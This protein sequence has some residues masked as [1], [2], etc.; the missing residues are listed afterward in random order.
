M[1]SGNPWVP[2]APHPHPEGKLVGDLHTAE[3][4]PPNTWHLCPSSPLAP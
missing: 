4:L 3:G 1:S 2:P